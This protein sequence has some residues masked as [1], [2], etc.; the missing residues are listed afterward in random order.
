MPS[1][2][3]VI[4][5]ALAELLISFCV[6]LPV[7]RRLVSARP[8]TLALAPMIGWAVFNTLA[9]PALSAVGFTRATSAL[10]CGAAVLSGVAILRGAAARFRWPGRSAMTSRRAGISVVSFGAAALFAVVPALAVWPKPAAGGIVLSQAMFDHS[11]AAIIDDIVRLGLPPGNPFFGG[12]APRLVYYYLWHFSAAIPGAVFGASG[13]EADIALTWFTAFASVALMMG[14]ANWFSGRRIASLLVVLLSLAASLK[15]ALRLVLPAD[16]LER[17][18]SQNPWPQSWIF[19]ASW[20]PQHLASA[21][22][23][24][25]AVL[26]L[27][28]IASARDWLMVPLLAVTVAA[29]FESSAWV[30]GVVFAAAGAPIGIAL[31]MIADDSRARLDLLTKAAAAAVLASAISFPFLLDMYLA[32]AARRAGAPLAFRPFDVLGP[33]VPQDLRPALDLPAYWV[34]LLAVQFPAIYFAGARAMAG[35]VAARGTPLAQQRCS[36][37]LV[38]LAGAS[39]IVSWLFTSTIAN[40]DLGARGVLPGILVLTIFAAAGLARWLATVRALAIAAVAFWALGVPG[41]LR[42]IKDN[43]VGLPTPS[44]AIFA[45]TPELWAAVR[46]YAAPDERVA[47]NPSFVADEVRWPVNI[48]WALLADRRSCFAGWNLARA[49][50]PLPEAEI[51]HLAALFKRVFAGI[52]TADDAHQLATRFHCSVVVM[53]PSDGAW[54]RDPFANNPYFRLVE[55]KAG[56]WRVY[57]IVDGVR[58]RK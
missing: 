17:A 40:N 5:C 37:G 3:N 53:T 42:I 16:Y 58:D 20:A 49:F 14:L 32:T 15:P 41:G 26:I 28:R 34:I 57:R 27:S 25:V 45:K 39:F 8:L 29:G 23:V 30:G 7:A 24:V 51:D 18:F 54:N 44:A 43:A 12:T 47:N 6:G 13:W 10:L 11:K 38:L 21:S 56:K 35:A 9:L 22:C 55:Q 1:P 19:Q 52:G 46:R 36:V 2:L 50:V 33:I 48:S 31:L 4:L